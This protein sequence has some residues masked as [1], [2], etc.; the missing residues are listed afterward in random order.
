VITNHLLTESRDFIDFCH[1]MGRNQLLN[2]AA[3]VALPMK[4]IMERDG[5]PPRRIRTTT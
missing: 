4:T 2:A 3:A 1:E 5:L